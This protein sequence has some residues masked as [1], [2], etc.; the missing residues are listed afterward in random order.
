MQIKDWGIEI[1]NPEFQV[2]IGGCDLRW[3]STLGDPLL[4]FSRLSE[5]SFFVG[6]M[7]ES[8]FGTIASSSDGNFAKDL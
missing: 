4:L 6:V 3:L 5:I 2:P 1:S 7:E 8:W